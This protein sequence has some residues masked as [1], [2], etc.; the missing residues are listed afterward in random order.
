MR[1]DPAVQ[2]LHDQARWNMPRGGIMASTTRWTPQGG[3]RRGCER[4][5]AL[6]V[7][8]DEASNWSLSISYDPDAG[9]F[10]IRSTLTRNHD[11][12]RLNNADPVVR[13]L[14]RASPGQ[15]ATGSTV[16]C[17]R[18]IALSPFCVVA[19]GGSNDAA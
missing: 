14:R 12:N 15:A 6:A 1:D 13:P 16:H 9:L 19:S 18:F 17:Q 8:R 7:L 5:K 3:V 10:R 4:L 2:A 11:R